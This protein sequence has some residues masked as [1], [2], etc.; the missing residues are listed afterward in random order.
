MDSNWLYTTTFAYASIE[1]CLF[2][3]QPHTESGN[4]SNTLEV[5]ATVSIPN[6]GTHTYMHVSFVIKLFC[7]I[8]DKKLKVLQY[9]LLAFFDFDDKNSSLLK[10]EWLGSE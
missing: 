3:L 7:L 6:L 5:H 1:C 8:R 4:T 2:Q 9:F 10:A